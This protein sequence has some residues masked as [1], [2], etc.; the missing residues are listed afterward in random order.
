MENDQPYR[1][2]RVTAGSKFFKQAVAA[3][4]QYQADAEVSCLHCGS[5]MN[6]AG[7]GYRTQVPNGL[8]IAG[9]ACPNCGKSHTIEFLR[10]PQDDHQVL[11]PSPHGELAATMENDE[12]FMREDLAKLKPTFDRDDE[13]IKGELRRQDGDAS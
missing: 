9:V 1:E 11:K 7:Q 8:R 4:R 5:A 12:Q 6:T 10:R 13:A 2:L 3:P